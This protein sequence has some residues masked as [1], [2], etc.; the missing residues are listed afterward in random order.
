MENLSNLTAV[1]T[2]CPG[3]LLWVVAIVIAVVRW[4]SHPVA[5][6]LV[7]SG[8]IIEV[9]LRAAYAVVPRLML[10]RGMAAPQLSIIYTAMGLVGLVGSGLI[11]AAVFVDRGQKD[12]RPVDPK[13]L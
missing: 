2:A 13:Q 7:L 9:M 4:Q 3:M 8:G 10:D 11:V 6:A 12:R 5:S 1:L